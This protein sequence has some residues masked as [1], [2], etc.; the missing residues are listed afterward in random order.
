MS[1]F[2]APT[3]NMVTSSNPVGGHSST[4]ATVV[5]AG[6]NV[7]TTHVDADGEDNGVDR[8]DS[9]EHIYH[10][11]GTSEVIR[12][13]K[14]SPLRSTERHNSLDN[15]PIIITKHSASR[16]PRFPSKGKIHDSSHD[17]TFEFPAFRM[18]ALTA[19]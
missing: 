13:S 5:K 11:I 8:E 17:K 7:A 16:K 10:Q 3:P 6:K 2:S 15:D 19:S 1:A 4:A 14:S 18:L 9:P 12:V